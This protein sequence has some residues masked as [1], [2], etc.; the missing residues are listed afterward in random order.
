MHSEPLLAKKDNRRSFICIFY[1]FSCFLLILLLSKQIR[2]EIALGVGKE[3]GQAKALDLPTDYH[4]SHSKEK[5]PANTPK[6]FDSETYLTL[7]NL[8]LGASSSASAGSSSQP[9]TANEMVDFDWKPLIQMY[10]HTWSLVTWLQGNV[11]K[12]NENPRVPFENCRGRVMCDIYCSHMIRKRPGDVPASPFCKKSPTE[13]WDTSKTY[14]W[15]YQ[16]GSP[17]WDGTKEW[18]QVLHA[19]DKEDYN[20]HAYMILAK[21]DTKEV[22]YIFG[23]GGGRG[24]DV[25]SLCARMGERALETMITRIPPDFLVYIMGHSEGS[26]WAICMD[27]FMQQR[28]MPNKRV[29]LGSGPRMVPQEMARKLISSQRPML[30]LQSGLIEPTG[31]QEITDSSFFD[32][33][34]F[35]GDQPDYYTTLPTVA[36][37]CGKMPPIFN[38]RICIVPDQVD[39]SYEMKHRNHITKLAEAHQFSFYRECL[40]TCFES[41]FNDFTFKPNTLPYR[42]EAYR[43]P[44]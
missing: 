11:Y 7:E 2:L 31:I 3:G 5:A 30:F 25:E 10:L 12:M 26:G 37:I 22:A 19:R 18:S 14:C 35:Q 4:G 34:T 13:C 9:Q 23:P 40:N 17:V 16:G 6:E 33:F 28:K 39:L 32:L 20:K 24:K 15:R 43:S 1:F 36:F 21:G 41:T 8:N 27:E 29:L 44:N 38:L 42:T